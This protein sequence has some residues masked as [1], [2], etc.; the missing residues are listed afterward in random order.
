MNLP[1]KTQEISEF[2]AF[3]RGIYGA[4][5]IFTTTENGFHFV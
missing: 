2:G 1:L 3:K 4:L 5:W